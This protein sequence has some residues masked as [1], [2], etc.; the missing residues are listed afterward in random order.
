LLLRVDQLAVVLAAGERAVPLL[1]DLV[2]QR[3]GVLAGVLRGSEPQHQLDRLPRLVGVLGGGVPTDVLTV[4]EEELAGV[5]R[6]DAFHPLLGDLLLTARQRLPVA[7][8]RQGAAVEVVWLLDGVP[9][10]DR[11]PG[12]VV[13]VAVVTEGE[14]HRHPEGR[15]PACRGVGVLVELA[16]ASLTVE[17][18]LDGHVERGLAGPVVPVDEEQLPTAALG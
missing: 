2:A 7:V 1:A 15:L 8:E 14:R 6:D 17:R 13:A 5:T 11:L 12:E 9:V 16:P 10:G 3:R 18:P 4:E